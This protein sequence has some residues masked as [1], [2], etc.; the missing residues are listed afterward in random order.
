MTRELGYQRFGAVGGD[1]GSVLAQLLGVHHPESLV[2]I[3]L[4]DLG[5]SRAFAQFQ[6]LSEAEQ[7]YFAEM[8]ASGMQEAPT[9]CSRAL[10][11]RRS[12]QG[13]RPGWPGR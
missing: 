11:R 9:P 4:V 10:N 2:G 6:D 7:R 12:P 1:G 3:H 8:Q 5:F 13:R